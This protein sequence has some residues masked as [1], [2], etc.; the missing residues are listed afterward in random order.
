MKWSILYRSLALWTTYHASQVSRSRFLARCDELCRVG[1]RFSVGVVGV[2]ESFEAL[3][4][5]RDELPSEVYLWVNAY[6]GEA[7]YYSTRER[8]FLQGIDPLFEFNTRFYESAGR[9]CYTGS[10]VVSVDDEGAIRRCHFVSQQLGNI[11]SVGFEGE[12]VDRPCPNQ[13]CH[14]HIG[15]V[16]LQDLPLAEVFGSG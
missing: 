3:A 13:S 1:V 4:A 16:H 5:L 12:L 14:C 6:K 9:P 15:Y 2:K 8:E 7:S 10:A 11:H